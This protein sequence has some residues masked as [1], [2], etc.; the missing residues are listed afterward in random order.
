MTVVGVVKDVM[1]A[2]FQ[3]QSPEPLVYLPMFG[4][5]ARSWVVAPPA[6]VVRTAR[7]E[8][9]GAD[10]REVIRQVAPEAPMYRVFTMTQLAARSMATLSF[11]MR[12]LAIAAGLALILGAVG[13][14]GVMAYL[15]TLRTRE[16]GVR[17][18]LG[19]QPRAVAAMMARQGLGLTVVGIAGGLGLFT[20]VARFLQSFLFGVVP[21]DPLTL[22]A[23]SLL[24]LGIAMLASWIPA[25]R[26]LRIAP[27][28]ALRAE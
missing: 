9:I 26:A 16:L 21:T 19:A 24:L 27:S 25:R 17:I 14:Y 23:A 7:A 4:H 6:Y 10:V 28:D 5:T 18:A 3:Q 1:L 13:L 11:T 15:V 20:L 12:T 22:A 8:T 2:D